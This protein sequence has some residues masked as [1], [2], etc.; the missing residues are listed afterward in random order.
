[1]YDDDDTEARTIEAPQTPARQPFAASS[2]S[3]IELVQNLQG[4]VFEQV[5]DAAM[6]ECAMAV[7]AQDGPAKVRQKGKLV[8]TFELEPTSGDDML[9]VLHRVE[10]K[11][12]T[13]KGWRAE[14]TGD[15]HPMFVNRKG[16]LTVVKDEQGKFDF[17]SAQ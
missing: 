4:G 9:D 1:M 15:R 13:I 6:A 10:F 5:L 16:A 17:G 7:A 11:H 2:P 14:Q 8:L 12:P 3:F